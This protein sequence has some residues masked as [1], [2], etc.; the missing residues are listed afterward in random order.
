[1]YL[2]WFGTAYIVVGIFLGF[3]LGAVFGVVL[4]RFGRA[5]RKT[6]IPFGNWLALGA[7][8]AIFVAQPIAD[9]YLGLLGR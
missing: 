7:V 6:A 5:G 4:M 2:G 9:W 1:L 3:V 8:L